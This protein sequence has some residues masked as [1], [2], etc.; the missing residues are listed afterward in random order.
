MK[1]LLID[2]GNSSLK[3]ALL[4]AEE[5]S[6]QTSL[7]YGENSPI[8]KYEEAIKSSTGV[9][10]SLVMVTVLGEKFT[11]MAEK[12]ATQKKLDFKNI[13]SVKELAGIKNAYKEPHKLGADRFVAMIAAYHLSNIET[14]QKQ[15]CI[16]IDS[17]TATTI[18][19]VDHNGQHLGGV[20]L[21]G[22]H[23]CTNSLLDNTEQLPMWNNHTTKVEVSI[24]SKETTHAI[25]SGCLIGLAGAI[26]NICLKM[27]KEVQS[28]TNEQNTSVVK[29][30]SG[31]ASEKLL[32][33]MQ[34]GYHLHE[35]LIIFGL[36]TITISSANI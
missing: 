3:W 28:H 11:Y 21:S 24:F 34:P 9:I 23:L 2:A 32:C 20:I 14:N 12:I 35:N 17:G 18:D 16:I 30:L 22:L 15:A 36:K 33:H 25:A 27:E 19:A 4:D 29:I 7:P 13:E 1:T 6:E 5:L 26:D 10:D 8:D 31:G